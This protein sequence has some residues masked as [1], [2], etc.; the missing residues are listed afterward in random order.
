[1]G[2]IHHRLPTDQRDKVLQAVAE[3]LNKGR[4][5]LIASSGDTLLDQRGRFGTSRGL[6]KK[7][8][9]SDGLELTDPS[10]S[11]RTKKPRESFSHDETSLEGMNSQS[12]MTHSPKL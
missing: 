8:L 3:G 7:M 1:M 11:S 10:N 12:R 6:L 2:A 9:V 5:E 4:C